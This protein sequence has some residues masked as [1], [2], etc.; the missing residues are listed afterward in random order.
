MVDPDGKVRPYLASSVPTFEEGTWNVVPNG[1]METTWK[2]RPNARWHD[3]NP[4][5]AEDAEEVVRIPA[6]NMG[7]GPSM[8]IEI[9]AVP[10]S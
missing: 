6:R 9:W 1:E 3:G 10:A 4:F 5:T 8:T 2:I 7:H